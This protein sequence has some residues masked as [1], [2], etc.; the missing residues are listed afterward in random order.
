MLEK[1]E[2]KP[3]KEPGRP[4]RNRNKAPRK[5]RYSTRRATLPS[6]GTPRLFS[7]DPATTIAHHEARP[8]VVIGIGLIAAI[9]LSLIVLITTTPLFGQTVKSMD[10]MPALERNPWTLASF[11]LMLY[12]LGA[13]IALIVLVLKKIYLRRSVR[14]IFAGLSVAG[15]IFIAALCALAIAEVPFHGHYFY[16]MCRGMILVRWPLLLL[17]GTSF[18]VAMPVGEAPAAIE[19]IRHHPRRLRFLMGM[20]VLS[21]ICLVF[22][23]FEVWTTTLHRSDGIFLMLHRFNAFITQPLLLF[24]ILG[25]FVAIALV[26]FVPIKPRPEPIILPRPLV[27]CFFWIPL[28]VLGFF[29]VINTVSLMELPAN[30]DLY[31]ELLFYSPLAFSIMG[32]AG[33]SFG[34]ALAQMRG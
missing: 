1:T 32:V 26:R 7:G 33:I 8:I 24:L 18:G 27:R 2:Q 19:K 31:S 21:W 6:K 29:C 30:Y 13:G 9:I 23:L 3:P 4:E 14:Y 25:L 20:G 15:F 10:L 17:L 12:C 28:F 34:V 11:L 5:T 22:L 16:G